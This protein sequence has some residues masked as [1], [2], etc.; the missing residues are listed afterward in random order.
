MA[1]ESRSATARASRACE[2]WVGPS[3]GVSSNRDVRWMVVGAPLDGAVRDGISRRTMRTFMCGT[4][5]VPTARSVGSVG[6][7]A[8]EEGVNATQALE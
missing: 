3:L 4:E 8:R 7:R 2:A 1:V 5:F 6:Q